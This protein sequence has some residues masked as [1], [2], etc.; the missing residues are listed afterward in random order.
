V[1]L[2]SDR[3]AEA[4]PIRAAIGAL[5]AMTA[6]T[7]AVVSA[8]HFGLV[9]QVG[10]LRVDDPFPGAAFPEAL[11]AVVL[12]IG[13]W[14][15]LARRPRAWAVALGTSLFVA[16]LTGFGLSITIGSPRTGDVVYHLGVLVALLVT[17]GLL[18]QPAGRRL[19]GE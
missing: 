9:I 17:I 15:V 8:I 6:L 10:A 4:Q 11:I 7:F 1:R 12:T 3:R 13:T 5:L 16:L 14:A 19:S 2:D 18:L